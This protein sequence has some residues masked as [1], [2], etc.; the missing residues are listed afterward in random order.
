MQAYIANIQSME[1]LTRT[2]T[3][4]ALLRKHQLDNAKASTR[5]IDVEVCAIR[6]GDWRLITFP[7][8]LT[9]QIGLN[10]QRSFP[11]QSVYIS[12]Y[13][14]GYIYYCPT[15][16]QMAN[17]AGAQEDCDCI[18]DPSWQ[19]SFERTAVDMLKEIGG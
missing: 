19:E 18:L 1:A 14:N 16:E 3:N 5:T 11:D 12:G 9:V 7:G 2:Q 15:A 6:L 10:L 8:E 17:P 13:T 4:L